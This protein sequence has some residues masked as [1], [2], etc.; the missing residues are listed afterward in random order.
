MFIFLI[1]TIFRKTNLLR[2]IHAGEAVGNGVELDGFGGLEPAS[3][4]GVDACRKHYIYTLYNYF[5]SSKL[6]K[7]KKKSLNLHIIQLF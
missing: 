4:H 7:F 3:Q 2:H 1:K 6:Y 5:N